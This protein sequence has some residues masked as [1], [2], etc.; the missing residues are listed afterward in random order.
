MIAVLPQTEHRHRNANGEAAA[1]QSQFE[2]GCFIGDALVGGLVSDL[3][4][5]G[6]T[7]AA[8]T[9]VFPF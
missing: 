9:A 5:S 6:S 2:S 8:D 4:C 7:R 3:N 1:A